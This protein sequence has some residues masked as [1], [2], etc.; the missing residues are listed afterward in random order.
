M[1][2]NVFQKI[3]KGLK[4]FVNEKVKTCK[5]I[6]SNDKNRKVMGVILIGVGMGLFAS[7]YIH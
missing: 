2:K 7:G 6:L 3:G 4:K 5:D 1:L